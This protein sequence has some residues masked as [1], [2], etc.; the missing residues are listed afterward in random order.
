MLDIDVRRYF[1]L[2]EEPSDFPAGSY[3]LIFGLADSGPSLIPVHARSADHARS[4]FGDSNLVLEYEDFIANG[5]RS[6]FLIRLNGSP[7]IHLV[8]DKLL[9]YSTNGFD[10]EVEFKYRIVTVGDKQVLE[11]VLDGQYAS[12]EV[13]S[14]GIDELVRLINS[15]SYVDKFGF[16]AV[17]LAEGPLLDTDFDSNYAFE[18]DPYLTAT[19]GT[20][21]NAFPAVCDILGGAAARSIAFGGIPAQIENQGRYEFLFRI[22]DVMRDYASGYLNNIPCVTAFGYL[23][24]IPSLQDEVNNLFYHIALNQDD[25]NVYTESLH[26]SPTHP[27]EQLQHWGFTSHQVFAVDENGIRREYLGDYTI[28]EN[29]GIIEASGDNFEPVDLEIRYVM[30]KIS[31]HSLLCVVC[32]P[33][34]DHQGNQ[35]TNGT[36]R[37]LGKLTQAGIDG[38]IRYTP[39]SYGAFSPAFP[40]TEDTPFLKRANILYP[41]KVTLGRNSY[42][43]YVN[44]RTLGSLQGDTLTAELGNANLLAAISSDVSAIMEDIFQ[45]EEAGAISRIDLLVKAQM[46]RY[47]RYL[48]SYDYRAGMFIDPAS[49]TRNY[50]LELDLVLDGKA[51]RLILGYSL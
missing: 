45:D 51:E 34:I 36:G 14:Q 26:L 33:S 50:F 49:L 23:G 29:Y 15:N 13:T 27:R 38:S 39:I 21:M 7:L 44:D 48:N 37:L 8:Q 5:G 4:I 17:K 32:D 43:A 11:V 3:S 2:T 35:R 10:A 28:D 47:T 12:F 42:A 16:L 6:A 30:P 31:V 22:S 25:E 46:A 1:N 24:D 20:I 19:P 9:L 41:A 40:S 18:Q